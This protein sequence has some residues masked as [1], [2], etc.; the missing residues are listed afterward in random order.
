[1]NLKIYIYTFCTM[2]SAFA[3]SSLN[4]EKII[5][6]N[7]VIEARILY[8]IISFALGYLISEFIIAFLPE[9]I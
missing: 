3:V 6:K 7:K 9:E 2:L 8:F 1:M 5:Y 4:L